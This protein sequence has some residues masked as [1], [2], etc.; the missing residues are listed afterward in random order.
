MGTASPKLLEGKVGD[1]W[2]II[3]MLFVEFS[4]GYKLPLACPIAS[5][6]SQRDL[7]MYQASHC[8]CTW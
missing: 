3:L 5:N 1:S 8:V 6:H 7:L 4:G 2:G